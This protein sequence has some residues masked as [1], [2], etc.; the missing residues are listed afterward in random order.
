M[1]H[2]YWL[3]RDG[4]VTCGI[5]PPGGIELLQLEPL[6]LIVFA[7]KDRAAALEPYRGVR[8]YI[9]ACENFDGYTEQLESHANIVADAENKWHAAADQFDVLRSDTYSKKMH[10][11]TDAEKITVA[12]MEYDVTSLEAEVEELRLDF[13]NHRAAKLETQVEADA[14]LATLRETWEVVNKIPD[15]VK[16]SRACCIGDMHPALLEVATA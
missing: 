15:P 14:A 8:A 3:G 12:A 16:C 2:K 6:D 5:E 13:E 1:S 4:S 7:P 11:T 9:K 10:A